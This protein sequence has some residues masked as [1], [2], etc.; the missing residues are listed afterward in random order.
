[1]EPTLTPVMEPISVPGVISGSSIVHDLCSRIA[2]KLTSNCDLRAIDAYSGYTAKVEIM[3]QL[4]DVYPTTV[5]AE[6]E[7]GKI[8]SQLPS[9]HIALGSEVAAEETAPSLERPIDP[10]GVTEPAVAAAKEK[11]WYAP[12]NATPVSRGSK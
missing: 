11:R 7:V 10:D 6:V 12:R 5:T 1:M 8:N 2:A 4:H 3:L 9:E